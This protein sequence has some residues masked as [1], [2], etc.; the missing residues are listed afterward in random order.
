MKN[1]LQS[2]LVMLLLTTLTACPS[3]P[4]TIVVQ[5]RSLSVVAGKTATFSVSALGEAPLI[6]Q[7][8]KNNLDIPGANSSTYTTPMTVLTDTGTF[9]QVKVSNANGSVTSCIATLNVIAAGSDSSSDSICPP[10]GIGGGT[11]GGTG[12]GGGGGSGGG[13]GGTGGGTGGGGTGGGNIPWAVPVKKWNATFRVTEEQTNPMSTKVI[14]GSAVFVTSDSLPFTI[15]SQSG[16]FTVTG[17]F[18]FPLNPGSSIVTL[19]GSGTINLNDGSV[20]FAPDDTF[21]PT[22]LLY[23]GQG[24][25]LGTTTFSYSNGSPPSTVTRDEQ[26]LQIPSDP[27]FYTSPDL[28][29]FSDH[30]VRKPSPTETFTYEW[31]FTRVN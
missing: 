13:G 2:L 11:G 19:K 24:T 8:Q 10:S 30:W 5:P 15:V 28:L 31:S 12:G 22:Q 6:Y 9:F 25:S 1:V 4:P 18:T 26:W 27:I 14:E 3:S 20:M 23:V 7:W 17:S 29:S 16:S 21:I